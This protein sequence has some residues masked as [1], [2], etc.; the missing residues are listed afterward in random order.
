MR[1]PRLSEV[2]VVLSLIHAA[3]VGGWLS[4]A[5]CLV[6]FCALIAEKVVTPPP[7]KALELSVKITALEDRLGRLEF[8]AGMPR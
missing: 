7:D 4:A 2:A 8:K 6:A 5:F 1:A 3:G